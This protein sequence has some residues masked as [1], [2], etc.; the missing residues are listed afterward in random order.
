MAL[1]PNRLALTTSAMGANYPTITEPTPSSG[2]V[3]FD[4]VLPADLTSY[5][6]TNFSS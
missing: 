1:I 5:A 6:P 3:A 2:S 4:E